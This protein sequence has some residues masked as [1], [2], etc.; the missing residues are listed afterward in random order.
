VKENR[1]KKEGRRA[2]LA[3][4]LNALQPIMEKT[5]INPTICLSGFFEKIPGQLKI[6]LKYF[7]IL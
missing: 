1:K 2:E 4:S 7:L 6:F 5:P 3:R